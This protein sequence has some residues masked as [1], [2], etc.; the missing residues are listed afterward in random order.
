MGACLA[1]AQ[2]RTHSQ[3]YHMS[4]VPPVILPCPG[5][6]TEAQ[7]AAHKRPGRCHPLHCASLAQ[8]LGTK[9]V[10]SDPLAPPGHCQLILGKDWQGCLEE[11]SAQGLRVACWLCPQAGLQEPR[12]G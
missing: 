5:P 3:K 6:G 12:V 11:V 8:P 9:A 1:L 10:A 2:G 4:C 7:Y